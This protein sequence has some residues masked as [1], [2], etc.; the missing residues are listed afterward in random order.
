ML[1]DGLAGDAAGTYRVVRALHF[2]HVRE[3]RRAA[4]QTAARERELW[5]ALHAG[6]AI[7]VTVKY[8]QPEAREVR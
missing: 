1:E 2:G 4:D 3:A 7:K 6:Q 8:V 5:N